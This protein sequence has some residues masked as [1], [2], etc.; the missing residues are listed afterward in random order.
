M[1]PYEESDLAAIAALLTTAAAADGL[2]YVIT[3][4]R[5]RSDFESPGFDPQRHTVV[6]DA[7]QIEGVP[8]AIPPGFG[9]LDIRDDEQGNERI[10]RL[11]VSVHPAARPLGLERAILGRLID[12]ARSN[13]ARADTP[14]RAKTTVKAYVSAKQ[15]SQLALYEQAGLRKVRTEWIM[16]RAL[17]EPIEE[18][19]SV[20]G[21][22]IRG[23]RFPED[24]ERAYQ[25]YINSFSDLFDF[26]PPSFEWWNHRTS[27]PFV[28]HELSWLAEVA[29]EPGKIAG[30]CICGIN[31]AE[32]RATGR[33]EGWI[34]ILGTIRGWRKK[35]LGRSLLLH[36]LHSLKNAGMN[37]ALLGVDSESLTGANF[38]YESAGF[39]IHAT[40]LKYQCAL[41]EVQP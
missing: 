19:R 2:D 10:Y 31:E 38:L 37:T 22:N 40:G 27:A 32:N 23:Y 41:N 26:H 30:F 3:E 35:G 5:L 20:K 12:L 6:A 8:E 36:G 33:K 1:R 28:R 17:G 14:D 21:V 39:Q 9:W 4:D 18:P 7:P 16:T 11:L 34:N 25:A 24:N 29:E 15:V 13:E